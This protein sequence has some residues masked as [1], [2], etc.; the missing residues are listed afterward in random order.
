MY[1]FSHI[2]HASLASRTFND[3]RCGHGTRLAWVID[4]ATD[5]IEAPLVG[6]RSDAEW[7]AEFA[8]IWLEG[9]AHAGAPPD[10]R[11]L[12][13]ALTDRAANAFKRLAG[14]VPEQRYAHPSAALLMAGLPEPG[15]LSVLAVGDCT[16]LVRARDGSVTRHAT[17]REDAG[18]AW[19]RHVIDR[20]R[21]EHGTRDGSHHGAKD[22]HGAHRADHAR[23]GQGEP[24]RNLILDDLKRAR[25]RM[26]EPGGYGVLSITTVPET[27]V[28]TGRIQIEPGAGV[29]LAS[30]GFMRL[31][32]VFGLYCEHDLYQAVHAV[33]PA[34]LLEQLRTVER[35]DADCLTHP[36]A[37]TCDD[38]T[39]LALSV[40]AGPT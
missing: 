4:G 8:Q 33:G 30:D 40:T 7:L 18:D 20:R 21:R 25:A 17:R 37:K 39:V 34:P 6:R 16:L 27:F 12:F 10:L 22:A 29:M 28:T 38:A 23:V 9:Y 2:T 14:A 15:I 3:D 35:N 26:N 5:L 32:D 36:R 11:T 13:D 19:L 1:Q 31:I 24:L